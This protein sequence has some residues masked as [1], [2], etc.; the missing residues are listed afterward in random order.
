LEKGMAAASGKKRTPQRE[1]IPE[2]TAAKAR[3]TPPS[4]TMFHT[5]LGIRKAGC[6]ELLC[7]LKRR[8][9]IRGLFLGVFGRWSFAGVV[10]HLQ[11]HPRVRCA[12]VVRHVKVLGQSFPYENTKRE[13]TFFLPPDEK[14]TP[15]IFKP[16]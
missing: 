4:H 7:I 11:R 2:G 12:H 13:K 6:F 8:K 5:P 10:P 3:K 14:G 16:A 15:T 1:D 9:C